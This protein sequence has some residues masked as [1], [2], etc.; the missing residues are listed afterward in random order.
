[1][2]REP[3]VDS[4]SAARGARGLTPNPLG[5]LQFEIME[6]L[7]TRRTATAVELTRSLNERRPA[8]LSHKTILTCLARLEAKGLVSHARE[9]RAYLF[10][11]TKSADEVSAWYV[12]GRFQ[13]LI[14]RFGDLAVAVFVE[15]IGE[16]PIRYRFLRQL[17]EGNYERGGP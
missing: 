4:T 13:D 15:Q 9:R 16:D 10:S 8:P 14:N 3:P 12:R 17:V 2:V 11:P 7:W 6:G 1:M 5:P